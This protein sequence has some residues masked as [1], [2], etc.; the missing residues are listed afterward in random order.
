MRNPKKNIKFAQLQGFCD[1]LA[2]FILLFP[3]FRVCRMSG[4]KQSRMN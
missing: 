3:K 4:S 2:A 1:I